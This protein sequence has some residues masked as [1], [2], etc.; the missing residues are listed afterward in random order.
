MKEFFFYLDAWQYCRQ[1]E[2]PQE[3]IVRLD[4]KTWGVRAKAR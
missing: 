4:W 3:R 1:H 2:L